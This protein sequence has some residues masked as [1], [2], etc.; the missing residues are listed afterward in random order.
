MLA[1]ARAWRLPGHQLVLE[2]LAW[3]TPLA[4]L[5]LVTFLPELRMYQLMA[6]TVGVLLVVALSRRPGVVAC[7][8]VVGFPLA[9]IV[10]PITLR[11]GVPTPIVRAAG[12]WK[13]LLVLTL[14]LAAVQHRRRHPV[15][16]ENLDLLAA[17]FLALVLLYY[18]L[19]TWLAS[20]D[21]LIPSGARTV[22]ARTFGLPIVAFLAARHVELDDRWRRRVA[23]CAL[24]AGLVVA[25]GAIVEIMFP[26]TW[27]RF[28]HDVLD[29]D[30]YQ[31][32]IFSNEAGRTFIFSDPTL[33]GEKT[34]RAASILGSHL[35]SA[36]ALLLPLAIALHI[37]RRHV[38]SRAVVAGALVAVGLALTQTRSALLGAALI[39]LGV[40]R[41]G[42][43]GSGNR[44]RLALAMA[45]A[46]VVV[47]PLVADTALAQRITGAITG[48]D[49]ESTPE[50]SERTRAAFDAVVDQPLGQGLGSSGGTANRFKVAGS[51]LPENHYLH[52]SLDLGVMGGVLFG[53]VVV[54]GARAAHRRARRTDHLLDA[55]AASALAATALAGL[56]LDSFSV[57]TTSVPL[58]VAVGLATA[59]D[60]STA[61]DPYDGRDASAVLAGR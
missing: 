11:A 21:L 53:A 4:V 50:H 40:L 12:S 33:S 31:R 39:A 5:V 8:L 60:A 46:A 38:S 7:V 56:F 19:P 14:V 3:L 45:L 22:A 9:E 42:S 2:R 47:L 27:E 28:L 58:F 57:V 43:G 36:Y 18:L 32:T 61:P 24:V 1:T 34:R 54:I 26:S 51:L 17:A 29:V 55:A 49:Q 44:V 20:T 48:T 23:T 30:T 15:R 37:L 16:P 52:V 41:S 35:D 10:L 13:E 59:A 6:A 25:V